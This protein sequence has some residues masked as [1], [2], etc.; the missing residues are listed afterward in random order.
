[1]FSDYARNA[2]RMAAL[3]KQRNVF[4]FTHDSIGLGEDGPT[5][6]PVEHLA[7]LR[8]IPNMSLWRPC[9]VPETMAAWQAALERRDGPTAL[10]LT[11]QKTVHQP[12]GEAQLADIRRGGYV[13]RD[14]DGTP[15]AIVIGTGS[16]VGLAMEA[17]EQLE[18][19]GRRVR[20]VSMPSVDTFEAQDASTGMRCCRHRSA[21]GWRWRRACRIPGGRW[22]GRLAGSSGWRVS[23]SPRP[24]MPSTSISA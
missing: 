18:A 14:C 12:R 11:R 1:M 20:V 19:E 3:M 6:Q 15:E 22:W 2:V 8:L 7:A 5:H 23:A 13:L 21:P 9:D 24:A 16:E 10:A 4:V 17:A